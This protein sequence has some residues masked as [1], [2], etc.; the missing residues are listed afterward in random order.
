MIMKS[1]FLQVT[2]SNLI[3]PKNYQDALPKELSQLY[4]PVVWLTTTETAKGNG[5]EGGCLNKY[6][7]RI[8]LR[9]RDSYEN[10]TL[11]SKN[12]RIKSSW[13]KKLSRVG[14]PNSWYISEKIIPLS[15]EEV[16]KIENTVTGEVIIDVENGMRDYTMQVEKP[17][18]M[19]M[20]VY[21]EFLNNR[22]DVGEI[23]EFHI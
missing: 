12:N 14:N 18:S 6:E 19:P 22:V 8:T 2:E 7:I 16:L 17:S 10:W 5:L 4:K 21:K 1:G 3:E 11:W 13:A 23:I 20:F 15:A 9:K